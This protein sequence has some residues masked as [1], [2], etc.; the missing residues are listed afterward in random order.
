LY[1]SER[2]STEMRWHDDGR[3]KDRK[4]RHPADSMA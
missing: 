3:I 4:L 2:T 1:M